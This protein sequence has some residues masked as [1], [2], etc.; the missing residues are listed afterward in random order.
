MD[1]SYADAYRQMELRILHG[2]MSIWFEAG[3]HRG[4]WCT[5][6]RKAR[7][8]VRIPTKW[9][10]G[11]GKGSGPNVEMKNLGIQ[12]ILVASMG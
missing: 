8:V 5:G 3:I 2:G 10:W 6:T 9:S 12:E 7:K 1:F 11:P 4:L